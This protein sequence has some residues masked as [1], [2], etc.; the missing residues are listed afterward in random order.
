MGLGGDRQAPGRASPLSETGRCEEGV[1]SG[2]R[3]LW[4][5]EEDGVQSL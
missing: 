2:A 3:A 5:E 1:L 4:G